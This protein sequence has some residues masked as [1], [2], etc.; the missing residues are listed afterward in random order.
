MKRFLITLCIILIP[1]FISTQLAYGQGTTV[2]QGKV[3]DASGEPVVGANIYVKGT[4]VGTVTDL[5]GSF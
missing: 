3:V 2:V 5:Q 4:T 1:A